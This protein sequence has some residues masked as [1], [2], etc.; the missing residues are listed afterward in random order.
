MNFCKQW[1]FSIRVNISDPLMNP[2]LLTGLVK[3]LPILLFQ[4][5]VEIGPEPLPLLPENVGICDVCLEEAWLYNADLYP[6]RTQF[7]AEGV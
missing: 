5:V 7:T 3:A 4:T 6:S 1:N 2:A